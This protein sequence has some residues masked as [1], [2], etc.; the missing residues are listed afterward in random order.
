MPPLPEDV[1]DGVGLAETA[2]RE[3][4]SVIPAGWDLPA[5]DASRLLY[6]EAIGGKNAGGAEG[7][8][9]GLVADDGAAVASQ[10]PDAGL[11][12][13]HGQGLERGNRRSQAASQVWRGER[14]RAR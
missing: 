11:V 13:G 4:G 5:E 1:A 10:R 12:L 3:D 2:D 8:A 6:G 9:V 14:S 7:R